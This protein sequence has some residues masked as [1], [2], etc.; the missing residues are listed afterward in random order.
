MVHGGTR[1]GLYPDGQVATV[2]AC[3]RTSCAGAHGEGGTAADPD[4]IVLHS[5]E[6]RDG[7]LK[8][9]R[10]AA[11]NGDRCADCGLNREGAGHGPYGAMRYYFDSGKGYDYKAPPCVQEGSR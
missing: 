10:W 11:N 7:R 1:H 6:R 9:H 5:H 2:S 8:R 3:S 4:H